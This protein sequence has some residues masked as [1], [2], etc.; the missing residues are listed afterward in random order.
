MA[1]WIPRQAVLIMAATCIVIIILA[2][3]IT[4]RLPE[5]IARIYQ[6]QYSPHR[7][8]VVG[9]PNEKYSHHPNQ[10]VISMPIRAG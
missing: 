4:P 6:A 9:T 7:I 5:T 10:T 1:S 8:A 3:G 2:Y